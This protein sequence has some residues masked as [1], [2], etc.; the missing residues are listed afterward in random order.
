MRL[1]VFS[2]KERAKHWFQSL[3]PN[4]ITCWD[5]LQQVFLKKYFPIGRPMTLGEP[6]LVSPNT[7]VNHYMR[8][9]KGLKTYLDHV[10]TMLS[11]NGS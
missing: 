2:L 1:F 9:G 8:L 11:P 10:H 7:R 4:S 6:S 3:D 5:Q